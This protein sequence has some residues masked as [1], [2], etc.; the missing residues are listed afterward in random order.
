MNI[1]SKIRPLLSQAEF[2]ARAVPVTFPEPVE[3]A[4]YI[5]SQAEIEK[6][7]KAKEKRERKEMKKRMNGLNGMAKMLFGEN[8]ETLNPEV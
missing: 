5:P 1:K 3:I 6:M 2:D 7:N 8:D 4:D